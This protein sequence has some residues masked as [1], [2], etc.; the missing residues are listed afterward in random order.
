[1]VGNS[2]AAMV[3]RGK[4]RLKARESRISFG[5]AEVRCTMSPRCPATAYRVGARI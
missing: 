2:Q 4:E 5:G 1:M 3:G